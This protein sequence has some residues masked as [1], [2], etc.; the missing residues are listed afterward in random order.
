MT[1]HPSDNHWHEMWRDNR[2]GFH[3][4]EVSAFLE[5]YWENNHRNVFVPLC[6]KTKDMVWLREQQHRVIGV[7]FN[8][9][10]IRDFFGEN[11]IE[12]TVERKENLHLFHNEHY[13]LYCNN[14]FD[15]PILSEVEIVFDRAA[16]VALPIDIRKKYVEY[17]KKIT[18][19]CMR[20]LLITYE[21]DQQQ[22]SGPP[23]S[24]THDMV[25]DLYHDHETID[26]LDERDVLQLLPMF[27]KRLSFMKECVYQIHR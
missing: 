18:P 17:L 19:N 10:A 12:H 20:I 22:M 25:K 23:F 5:K 8:E 24:I 3:Q 21:Y 13:Q 6:G 2:I 7:E 27:Q 4:S 14:F 1:Q 15:L 9:T 26:K 11:E 16:L